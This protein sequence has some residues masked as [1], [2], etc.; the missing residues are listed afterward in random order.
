[1]SIT[2]EDKKDISSKFGKKTANVMSNVTKD[3][4]SKA[5]DSAK[6]KTKKAY[7]GNTMGVLEA[8]YLKDFGKPM[9][10]HLKNKS[11]HDDDD[12]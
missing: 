10:A 1:M 9:P 8:K 6:S 2:N 12:Y 7:G 3:Y 11:L 4:K 5:L